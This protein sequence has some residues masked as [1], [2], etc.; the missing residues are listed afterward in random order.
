MNQYGSPGIP[1]IF[2]Y[3]GGALFAFGSLASVAFDDLFDDLEPEYQ[4]RG[5]SSRPWFTSPP[6]SEISC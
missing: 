2:L 1:D 5:S 3:V 6:R 4:E